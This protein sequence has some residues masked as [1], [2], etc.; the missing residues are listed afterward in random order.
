[1]TSK[2]FETLA[3]LANPRGMPFTINGRVWNNLLA[4]GW[5]TQRG[6]RLCVTREGRKA[7]RRYVSDLVGENVTHICGGK[8]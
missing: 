1:V 5:V 2:Q 6:G 8:S 3:W 4:K 7:L